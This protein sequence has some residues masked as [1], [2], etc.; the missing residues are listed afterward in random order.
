[1]ASS[2]V[3]LSHARY[4]KDKVRVFRIVR[5]EKWHTVAEYN[6]TALLEGDIDVSY[7]KAD[8]SV[9]V[10]TDSIKNIT[11]HLAK[12]SPH[13]LH[14]ERFALHLGTYFVSKY[15]HIHKAFITIEQ[16]RWKRIDVNGQAHSHSFWRD[17]EEKR[18]V[19]VEID[20]TQ[21]KDKIVAN[22]SAGI[23]DLLGKSTSFQESRHQR[24]HAYIHHHKSY[25]Q[26]TCTRRAVSGRLPQS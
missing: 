10:A 5:E 21:G 7:T 25:D 20:A 13:V 26:L 6:V 16:L 18:I 9:V 15:A 14:P 1:M 19:E 4:G 11:Y 12:T 24:T 3:Y 22:V 23:K 8:N 17:G 2:Q